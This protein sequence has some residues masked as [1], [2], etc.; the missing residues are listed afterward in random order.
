M[1]TSSPGPRSR[2]PWLAAFAAINAFAAYAGAFGLFTGATDFG[3]SINDRLPFD[4]LVLAGLALV[5]IV[6]I[7]LT[8]LAWSAFTGGPRTDDLAF[9]AG[10]LLIGW[11]IGQVLVIRAFSLF[12]PAYLAVGIFLIGASHRWS[13]S[14]RRRGVLFIALGSVLTAVGVGLLPHPI[15][16][17]LTVM[18]L[19]AVIVLLGGI[20]L[21][22]VGA[23]STLRGRHR[24]GA[25]GG[26]VA[27]LI[28]LVAAVSIISPAVAATTVPSTDVTATPSAM[29]LD[30]G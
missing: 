15:K 22:V 27:V 9:A 26:G 25:L 7:P 28:V 30:Y 21:V 29:G 18:S 6:G 8:L 2:R 16:N 4:S 12:Q 5:I 14:T 1:T 11:I 3:D 13:L 10:L 17:G 20:A 23:A 24:L 19:V